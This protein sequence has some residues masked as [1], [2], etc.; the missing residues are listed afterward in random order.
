MLPQM[1]FSAYFVLSGS[2]AKGGTAADMDYPIIQQQSSNWLTSIFLGDEYRWADVG[3]VSHPL[4]PNL[5]AIPPPAVMIVAIAGV[6]HP[7]FSIL[8]H[9]YCMTLEP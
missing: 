1:I 2:W 5:T 7:I 3:C 6:V 4:F 8:F 9:Y